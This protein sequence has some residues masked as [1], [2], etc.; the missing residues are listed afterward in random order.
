MAYQLTPLGRTA[1][2]TPKTAYPRFNGC[3]SG[4]RFFSPG[5]ARWISRDPIGES[6]GLNRLYAAANN[7]LINTVDLLGL[8]CC[9]CFAQDIG[10]EYKLKT[11]SWWGVG[12]YYDIKFTLY[13]IN[14]KPVGGTST[15]PDCTRT[16]TEAFLESSG[17][18]RLNTA[19][20]LIGPGE[21]CKKEYATGSTSGCDQSVQ[22]K[23]L[24][25]PL[26]FFA[27]SSSV[28]RS[29]H[30][31]V[32]ISVASGQGCAGGKTKSAEVWLKVQNGVPDKS[33]EKIIVQ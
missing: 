6:D 13:L 4:F 7:N 22:E 26:G 29:V 8:S 17:G 9:C 25:H 30:L 31:K 18:G 24:S 27:V 3:E 32:T 19:C 28:S 20:G 5:L 15:Q 14:M 10:V 16:E 21:N 12:Y 1:L 23:F 2:R 33:Y 11:P